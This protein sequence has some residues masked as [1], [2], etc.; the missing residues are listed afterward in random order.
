MAISGSLWSFLVIIIGSFPIISSAMS[1]PPT[2][3]TEPKGGGYI[4]ASVIEQMIDENR[5]P[6][7]FLDFV[8][9]DFETANTNRHSACALAIVVVENGE[10]AMQKKWLINPGTKHFRFTYLHGI[11]YAMVKDAP[12]FCDIWPEV[13][14]IIQGKY[15]VAHFAEFDIEVLET[16]I[17]KYELD[18]AQY[19]PVCSCELSRRKL[20]DLE[21][22]KLRTV[23]RYLDI[24]LKHHDPESDAL[25][26]A[27]IALRIA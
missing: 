2:P 7:P 27:M 20:P 22:H 24:P 16:L 15:L 25:A 11:T 21:N 19:I 10:V 1:D 18:S 14:A 5:Y 17:D 12:M 23:C 6:R 9:I 8:A 26:A 13:F 4:Y 3:S